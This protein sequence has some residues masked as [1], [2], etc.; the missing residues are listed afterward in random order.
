MK[1]AAVILIVFCANLL[2]AEPMQ[3]PLPPSPIAEFRGWL[4][5]S[6]EERKVALAKRSEKSRQMLE[7][8][9]EEYSALPAIERERRLSASEMQWYLTRLLHM[10]KSQRDRAMQRVPVPWQPMVMERLAQWDKMSAEVRKQALDHKLVVEYLSTPTNQQRAVLRSLNTQERDALMQRIEAWKIL[11]AFERER[12]DERLND[13]F[14][15][16]PAKQ[17]ETLNSF[18]AAERQIMAKTLD[19]YRGLT[20]QQREL[21]IQSFAQFTTR[22]AAMKRQEQIAFL[23]NVERWQE[24]SQEQRD[25]WRE[26]VSIVPPMPELPQPQPPVPGAAPAPLP[27]P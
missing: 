4:T 24:M 7:R 12:M 11:P 1:A 14:N 22:F 23:K 3:P 8:K 17:A 27:P 18:T 16:N 21:C 13:F 20:P 10:P 5:Q 6:P 19:A 25:M 26:V 2:G 9:I 15:T